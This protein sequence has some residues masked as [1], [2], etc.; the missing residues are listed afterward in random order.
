MR[1][2]ERSVFIVLPPLHMSRQ[3]N[4]CGYIDVFEHDARAYESKQ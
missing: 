1:D 3:S 4:G 2:F